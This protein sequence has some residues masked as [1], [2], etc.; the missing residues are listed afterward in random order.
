MEQKTQE[1]INI[2]NLFIRFKNAFFQLW[3]LI[4]VLAILCGTLLTLRDKANFVPVYESR[5]IFTVESGYSAEDIFSTGAYY[6]QYAAEQL[7][8][9]FPQI[10]NTD[11][12]RDLVV[13]QLDKGYINGYA[14]AQSVMDTNMLVLTVH[15]SDP[16][17]AYDYLCAIIDCY[18][19][20]A[21]YMVD[22]PTVKIMEPPRMPTNYYNSV[23]TLRS[24]AKGA[25]IGA[26]IG[27]VIIFICAILTKTIQTVDELK[28]TV[29]LPILIAL[30]KITR[31]KRRRNTEDKLITAESDPNM[32]ESLRGLRMKVKKLLD[33]PEKK[34]VLVTSTLAGEGKTTV[35][36]NLALSLIKD[37]RKVVLLDAD[38][39]NQSIARVLG[40][41]SEGN[42]LMNCLTNQNISILD[43]V[44]T[45]KDT[46]LDFISGES[47]DN[48]HYTI[49]SVAL[50][51]IL[52]AL[53]EH[54]EYIIIDT[55]PSEIVSDSATLCRCADCVLYVIRQDYAQKSHV[56]NAITALH[57]KDVKIAGCI[58][59]GVPQFHR[60]YGYGYRSTYGYGYD[61]G[62]RSTYGYGKSD[63]GSSKYGY[64]KYAPSG[65]NKSK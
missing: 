8:A 9:V 33:D 7:A 14:T 46:S 24:A 43:C 10:L 36:I 53:S 4:L 15:S 27:L 29:N 60:H 23:S 63:Y 61:Y 39:R 30:P 34:T 21:V 25:A 62:Y 44:R 31:K 48:R 56:L 50:R 47:T 18:P 58:F 12:M 42:S 41:T 1:P 17:D 20:V 3:P 49:S 55:P 64:S 35:A 45:A 5:A 11:I 19:Q 38:L 26:L 6:D 40:E 54:Y 52:Q 2:I 51:R 13:Q 28:S 59:N 22:N 57:Q 16:E 37:G 65:K 32:S